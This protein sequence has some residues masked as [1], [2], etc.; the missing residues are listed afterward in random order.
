MIHKIVYYV[1]ANLNMPGP[2]NMNTPTP[3]SKKILNSF[4]VGKSQNFEHMVI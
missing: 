3:L 1:H 2:H 4:K